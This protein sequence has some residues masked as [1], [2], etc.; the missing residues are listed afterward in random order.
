MRDYKLYLSDIQGATSKII[1]FT[2]GYNYKKFSM[3]DRT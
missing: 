3:D 2:K 1:T